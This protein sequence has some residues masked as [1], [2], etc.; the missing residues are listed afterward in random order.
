MCREPTGW[1]WVRMLWLL[2]PDSVLLVRVK[3]DGSW[4]WGLPRSWQSPLHPTG[5]AMT[6][7][8]VSNVNASVALSCTCRGSGNLQEEC[9]QL[10]QSFSHN[11]CLS[12][13]APSAPSVVVRSAGPSE[14]KRVSSIHLLL[15][16]QPPPQ[17]R[18]TSLSLGLYS[19]SCSLNNPQAACW[20]C[21]G[22][23]TLGTIQL[24]E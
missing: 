15:P 5:T 19:F 8:F 12:E 24:K 2:N 13:C 1:P 21:L 4:S 3:E 9:E 11:P 10:E 20:T 14:R 23:G 18:L 16:D 6:P 22:P 7:N 17:K